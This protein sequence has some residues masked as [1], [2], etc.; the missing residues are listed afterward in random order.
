MAFVLRASIHGHS[1][2][3]SRGLTREAF[4]QVFYEKC[5]RLCDIGRDVDV[6]R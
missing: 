2:W 1:L 6:M 5:N 4:R 3:Y